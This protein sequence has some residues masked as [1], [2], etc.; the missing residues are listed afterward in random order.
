[1][2]QT[3]GLP[4]FE[5]AAEGNPVAAENDGYEEERKMAEQNL[6]GKKVA[7]LVAD[8]F[9]RVEL[10]EPRTALEEA[11]AQTFIVSPA[12][13]EVQSV[14]HDEKADKFKV[15]VPLEQANADNYDALLLPGGALNPDQLRMIDKAKQ[16]VTAFDEAGKPMAIICH[17]PWTLVSAGLVR[18]RTMTSWPSIQDDIR[19]AG[20]KWV[21]EETVTDDNWVTSRGP[22]D[23]P[24]FNQQMVQLF[25]QGPKARKREP[26][27][28]M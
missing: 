28:A 7:I 23:I 5:A 21:N 26:V 16:F 12:Q 20:A 15:D 6:Q 18:G 27:Q 8:D 24:A 13:G 19:N 11:G 17:A 9:E 3:A 22:Q 4:V 14:N 25:A 2:R 10:V 1:M